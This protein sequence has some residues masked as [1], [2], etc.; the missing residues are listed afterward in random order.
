MNREDEYDKRTYSK[1]WHMK[2]LGILSSWWFQPNW[3]VL[4]KLEIFPNV[5]GENKKIETTT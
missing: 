1:K 3:K 2:M 5:R 4:V